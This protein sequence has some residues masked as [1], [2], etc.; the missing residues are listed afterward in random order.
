MPMSKMQHS[1]GGIQGPLSAQS[2][3]DDEFWAVV[4]VLILYSC[5]IFHGLSWVQSC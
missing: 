5:K 4:S 1:A 2:K 3:C